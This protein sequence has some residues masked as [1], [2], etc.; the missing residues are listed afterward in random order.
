[1]DGNSKA[2]DELQFAR[3]DIAVNISM[4]MLYAFIATIMRHEN[5]IMTLC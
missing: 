2:D 5:L 3:E 4:H 1:M